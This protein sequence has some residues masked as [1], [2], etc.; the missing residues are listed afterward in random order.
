MVLRIYLHSQQR[1]QVSSPALKTSRR[2][3]LLEKLIGAQLTKKIP[4]CY[5][6]QGERAVKKSDER[7]EKRE[8]DDEIK[9]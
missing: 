8:S 7:Y 3:V 4:T 6:N 2:R 5:R 1:P 9:M